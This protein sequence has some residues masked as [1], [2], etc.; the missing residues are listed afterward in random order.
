[1]MRGLASFGISYFICLYSDTPNPLQFK[2]NLKLLIIRS[3]CM[4]IHSFCLGLAQFILPIPVVHIISCSGT[5]FIFIIDYF[6]HGTTINP[7]QGIGIA[8]GLLGVCLVINGNLLT[9][10]FDPSYEYKTGFSNYLFTDP[11]QITLFTLIYVF[12]TMLWGYGAILTRLTRAN[13]FQINFMLGFLCYWLGFLC[14]PSMEGLGYRQSSF[15]GIL[16][17][18]LFTGVPC[19]TMQVLIITSLTMTKQTGVLNMM[20]FGMVFVGYLISIFRY[21]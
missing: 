9:K 19:F 14:L 1:M 17:V 2:D 18:F 11:I 3:F 12:A 7:R 5:L 8:I 4:T 20:G 15:M 21:H 10:W 6:M 13:T 16:K